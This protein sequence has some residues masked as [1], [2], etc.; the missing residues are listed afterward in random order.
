LYTDPYDGSPGTSGEGGQYCDPAGLIAVVRGIPEKEMAV[1]GNPFVAVETPPEFVF[2]LHHPESKAVIGCGSRVEWGGHDVLLMTM[3]QL[4]QAARFN[5]THLMIGGTK[6]SN[7]AMHPFVIEPSKEGPGQVG[8]VLFSSHPNEKTGGR[9]FVLI[10]ASGRIMSGLGVSK[11]KLVAPVENAPVTIYSPPTAGCGWRRCTG[12]ME[13][14]RDI[15]VKYHVSTDYGTSGSPLVVAG[16]VAGVHVGNSGSPSLHWNKGSLLPIQLPKESAGEMRRKAAIEW[17]DSDFHAEEGFTS[18]EEDPVFYLPEG[19]GYSKRRHPTRGGKISKHARSVRIE[20]A[21]AW[22]DWDEDTSDHL[23]HMRMM[24]FAVPDK[25][26][27]SLSGNESGTGS[28]NSQRG[29]KTSTPLSSGDS[30]STKRSDMETG[31]MADTKTVTL[32][33]ALDRLDALT[34]QFGL[35]QNQLQSLLQWQQQ[36]NETAASMGGSRQTAA[37]MLSTHPSGTKPVGG[38]APASPTKSL[39]NQK[40]AQGGASTSTPRGRS[41][42]PQKGGQQPDTRGLSQGKST[43]SGAQVTSKGSIAQKKSGP[44]SSST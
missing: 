22:A 14:V 5:A 24:G 43:T 30:G 28:L 32:P 20:P 39:Q 40:A 4:R 7:T 18:D 19:G 25:E 11:A 29:V 12:V 42:S 44:N 27:L 13:R 9:D 1:P 15:I 23:A 16:G 35:I 37:V 2:T 17:E 36:L 10:R 6:F 8:E 34:V 21:N 3:H 41:S 33:T 31:V 26:R 38:N